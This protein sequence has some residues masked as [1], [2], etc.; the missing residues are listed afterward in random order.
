V[1]ALQE[2]DID[3]FVCDPPNLAWESLRDLFVGAH[4]STGRDMAIGRRLELISRHHLHVGDIPQEWHQR[5]A[6][7]H[8]AVRQP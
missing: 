1:V 7:V 4:R 6:P 2:I 8:R 5:E 3:Y